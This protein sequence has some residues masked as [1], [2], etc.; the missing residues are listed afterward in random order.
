MNYAQWKNIT[1]L[2]TELTKVDKNLSI[3][4]SGIPL[5]FDEEHLYIN[6]KDH[7]TLVIG[8]TGSG[9]TQTVVL[10]QAKL[11]MY[12]NESLVIKDNN[13]ELY[14]EL[15]AHLEERGYKVYALNFD[16][17]TL[18]NNWNP[19]TL[20]Y[21]LYK[22]GN[23]DD[24]QRLLENIGYYLFQA[25]DPANSD[26]FWSTSAT[27]YF[28]GI[29]LYL[30][31][32]GKEDEINFNSIY[33]ITCAGEEKKDNQTYFNHLLESLDRTSP[34]YINL[35]GT[36]AAPTDTRG[37]ILSVFKQIIRLLASRQ[38]LSSMLST[39]DFNLL[40]IDKDKFAIFL[41][42]EVTS[43]TIR[44]EPLFVN[45]LY[46]AFNLKG[47]SSHR[48]NIIL[49]E[50]E[51]LCPL[52]NFS[53]LLNSSRSL[54]LKFTLIIKSMIDLER[55]YGKENSEILKYTM[56]CLIYLLSNDTYT[57]EEICRLCG[58]KSTNIPLINPEELKLLQIFEAIVLIPRIQPIKTKL[59]PDYKI[60]WELESKKKE[61]PIRK[62][63]D[64]KIFNLKEYV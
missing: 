3:S 36:L 38:N 50:F 6:D 33:D 42:G 18:G 30:F 34:T 15:G 35:A 29:S 51:S 23:V 60:P 11:A 64:Y 45:Q 4:R 44:L 14:E 10:P 9:K 63:I 7:H 5:T 13:G 54:N 28:V 49:D 52:D 48:V 27:Q 16:S 12:T 25:S 61:Q 57:Q 21:K 47:K 17:P 58:N 19:L 2:K 31:E 39:S 53:A 22:E 32:H 62:K 41:I 56:G 24:A 20:P 26:P 55:Q 8:C 46:Y 40:D 1:E 37:G 43:Y 59:I